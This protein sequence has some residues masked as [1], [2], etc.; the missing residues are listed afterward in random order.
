MNKLIKPLFLSCILYANVSY[1]DVFNFKITQQNFYCKPKQ[2][3]DVY[4]DYDVFVVNETNKTQ[5]Y[6]LLY[7]LELITPISSYTAGESFDIAPHDTF[8][9]HYH[10]I[11]RDFMLEDSNS[12]LLKSNI[13]IFGQPETNKEMT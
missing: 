4:A 9:K 3:C 10:H 12:Y 6:T 7:S 13:A 1:P 11:W 5:H 2:K 8:K